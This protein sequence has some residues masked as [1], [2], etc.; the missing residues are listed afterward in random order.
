MFHVADGELKVTTAVG[1][2]TDKAQPSVAILNDVGNLECADADRTLPN[3]MSRPDISVSRID[4]RGVALC[5]NPKVV[6]EDQA[7]LL[8]A[9]G[10]P[11][12]VKFASKKSVPWKSDDLWVA[13]PKFERRLLAEYFDRNHNYRV[14]KAK[15][16]WRPSSIACELGSGY[17]SMQQAANNWEPGDPKLADIHGTPTLVDFVNWI[18]YPAVLRTVRAHSNPLQSK[19]RKSNV[20]ELDAHLGGPAWAWT[21]KG[22]RL[23]PSLAATCGSGML[24]WSLLHSLYENGQI[25][26]EP[27]FYQHGGCDAISPFGAADLPYDHP[28]YGKRQG[29]ESLL[30]F[31]SGLALIGRAKV[32]YDEPAGFAR[33]TARRPN[34]WRRVG[35]ILRTG[36]EKHLDAGRRRNRPQARVLLERPGRLDAETEHGCA[37]TGRLIAL[38]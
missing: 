4:A 33:A 31:G 6:G 37:E 34:I 16:A 20:D 27:C 25:P 3:V 8:D 36:I 26:P 30:L 28:Q 11:E 38:R 1:A 2:S 12:A 9:G 13:D 32:Y 21:R 35:E 23:E 15:I 14:G 5:A 10:K 17:R 19:F 18:E 22:D 24:S 7:K 29:A